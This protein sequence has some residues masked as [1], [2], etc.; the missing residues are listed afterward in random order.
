MPPM[1]RYVARAMAT[2]RQGERLAGL[3][4]TVHSVAKTTGRLSEPHPQLDYHRD[5]ESAFKRARDLADMNPGR[6]FVVMKD[7]KQVG[8]HVMQE[9]PRGG[10]FHVSSS[11]Q[12]VYD[13]GHAANHQLAGTGPWKK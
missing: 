4:Y 9:G 7:D 2:R 5:E 10:H 12:K 6:K 11:G 8:D 1:P 3:P 13:S